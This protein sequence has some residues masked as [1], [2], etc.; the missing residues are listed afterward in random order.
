MGLPE[1]VLAPIRKT[2]SEV[3]GVEVLNPAGRIHSIHIE[4]LSMY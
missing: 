4:A 1:S 2:A 3:D